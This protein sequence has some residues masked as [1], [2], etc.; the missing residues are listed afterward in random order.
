MRS[1]NKGWIGIALVILFGASLFFFRGSS[2][3]SN[4]FNSDN[5]VANISGTQISTTKFTRSL[6]MNIA[7]FSQMIGDKLTREQIISFQI[8]QLVMQNLINNAI[9]ENEFNNLNYILD[10]STIAKQTK[11][12]FP[13]LYKNNKINDDAL[14][15]F[16]KQQRLKIEDLVNIINYETRA[17][18][19]DDLFFNKNYPL[20][21]TRKIN[22][23]DNQKRKIN[24]LKIPYTNINV[25]NLNKEN[26]KITSPEIIDYYEENSNSYMFSERRDVSYLLLDKNKYKNNFIPSENEII[27]YF[28][29]NKNLFR[30]PEKRSFKQFNFKSIEEAEN[31]KK[32]VEGLTNKAIAEYA[33]KNNIKYNTFEN[34]DSNQVLS[35]LSNEIFSINI[36]QV[37]DVITT[38]LANHIIVLD[39]ITSLKEPNL[40]EAYDNI[41]NILTSVQLDNFFNDLKLKINE[42]ILDGYSF[43]QLAEEN[44]LQIKSYKNFSQNS[45][46]EKKLENEI[47][48][49]SFNV[50]K[51]FIS[52]IFKYDENISYIIYVEQ[53]YPTETKKIDDIFDSVVSDYIRTKKIDFAKEIFDKNEKTNLSNINSVF[54]ESIE[55]DILDVKSNKFPRNLIENIFD[56]GV[57][58]VTFSFDDEYIYFAELKHIEINNNIENLSEINLQAEFKEAFGREIIKTK[59][60]SINEELISGLLSQYK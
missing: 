22:L 43:N 20:E 31:F 45:S 52:D 59:N 48:N 1:L 46:N 2:R 24:F 49:S 41:E 9:F 29:N 21:L 16:L 18:V 38:T 51:E 11:K 25:P 58:K 56:I 5:F 60:I 3:Y 57:N 4:L 26:F 7:Q 36:N 39:K 8:H 42:Q 44:N 55:Q 28:E 17:S 6:E 27:N 50:N 33:S 54:N 23:F 30:N 19:F 35:D 13:N 14:N 53:V 37:S 12:R 34:L 47:K 10:D 32:E 15:S 40:N